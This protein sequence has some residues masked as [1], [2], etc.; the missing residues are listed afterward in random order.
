MEPGVKKTAMPTIAGIF[1]IISGAAKLMGV[2]VLLAVSLLMPFES[3]MFARIQHPVILLSV[4]GILLVIL[5]VLAIIGGVYSL[6]R[7]NFSLSLAGS[8]AALLPFNLLGLA[9][10]ILIALSKKEFES[11][12]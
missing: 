7:K 12:S 2:L 9:A 4:V 3:R 8:I 6:K 5:G 10:I 1:S 11:V